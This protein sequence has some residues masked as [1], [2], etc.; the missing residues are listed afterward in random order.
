MD[1]NYDYQKE[2]TEQ[3]DSVCRIFIE[4][5]VSYS[6]RSIFRF[7]CVRQNAE[8]LWPFAAT[9]SV[10]PMQR[11]LFNFPYL[12][13]TTCATCMYVCVC[14]RLRVYYVAFSIFVFFAVFLGKCMICVYEITA[15]TIPQ[16][17]TRTKNIMQ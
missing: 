4:L 6:V 8:C 13:W 7:V 16:L 15:T 14:Q 17:W 1:K 2:W 9:A 5:C 10:V 12:V 11:I 3:T